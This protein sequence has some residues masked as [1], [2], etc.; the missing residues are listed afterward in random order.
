MKNNSSLSPLQELQ[1]QLAIVRDR[2]RSVARK[3]SNGLYL[4]GPAGTSKTYTVK[5]TLDDL[6]LKRPYQYHLGH[7][8]SMGLFDLLGE[9]HDRIIVLDDV[10]ELLNSKIAL[11]IL[12]AA[13][14]NQPDDTGERIVK[15]QRQGHDEIVRFTGGIILISNL[16]LHATPLLDALKSRVQLSMLQPL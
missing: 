7:I 10:S 8:T 1:Q 3:L 14:G 4:F 2:V 6:K 9:C 12:L 15:Y 16:K 5:T 13:L 11:Q